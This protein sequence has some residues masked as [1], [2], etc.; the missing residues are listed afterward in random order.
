MRRYTED[1]SFYVLSISYIL[2]YVGYC[3]GNKVLQKESKLSDSHAP[4]FPGFF[5]SWG[6]FPSSL[7]INTAKERGYAFGSLHPVT[8]FRL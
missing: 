5:F 2:Q 1:F 4:S 7:V 6:P 8:L 3:N